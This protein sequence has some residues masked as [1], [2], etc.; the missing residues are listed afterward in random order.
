[1]LDIGHKVVNKTGSLL[2]EQ[3]H[4]NKPQTLPSFLYKLP[5]EASSCTQWSHYLL[6]NFQYLL[7][8]VR[9]YPSESH[10][11]TRSILK[12]DMTKQCVARWLLLFL[13]K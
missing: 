6:G 3:N 5:Q 9:T 2:M 11:T 10:K 4:A 13:Y 8:P 7:D 1:M 12:Q